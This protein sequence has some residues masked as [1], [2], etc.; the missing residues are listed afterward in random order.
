MGRSET[1]VGGEPSGKVLVLASNGY[2]NT[3]MGGGTKLFPLQ[4][5][6]L[7]GVF[8]DGRLRDFEDL[9]G[10]DFV[11]TGRMRQ[12]AGAATW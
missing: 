12:H 1:A 3:S 11:P 2:R 6:G 10:Y 8:T 9:A 5:H 4:E 7:A